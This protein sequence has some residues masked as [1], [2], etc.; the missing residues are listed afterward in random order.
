MAAA[1]GLV[2]YGVSLAIAFRAGAWQRAPTP[3]SP[4]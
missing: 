2:A 1:A 3:G 4:A